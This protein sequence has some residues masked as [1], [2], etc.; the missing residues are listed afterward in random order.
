[1]QGHNEPACARR[2]GGQ[3]QRN[4][5]EEHNEFGTFTVSVAPNSSCSLCPLVCVLCV[6]SESQSL[7]KNKVEQRLFFYHPVA[8]LLF[9]IRYLDDIEAGENA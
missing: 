7:A 6:P 8:G 5:H 4:A 2:F 3:A 9:T 1:M